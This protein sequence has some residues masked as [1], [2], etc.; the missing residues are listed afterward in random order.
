MYIFF[1][2]D[3]LTIDKREIFNICTS[4]GRPTQ[5]GL[6]RA[7]TSDDIYLN[8]LTLLSKAVIIHPCSFSHCKNGSEN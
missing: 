2:H 1:W 6:E 8:Q 3:E 5:F 4:M 7:M